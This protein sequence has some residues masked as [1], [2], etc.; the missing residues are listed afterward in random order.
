MGAKNYV[1][2]ICNSPITDF[3]IC[4]LVIQKG[5]N[6]LNLFIFVLNC[7]FLYWVM[8]VLYILWLLNL[9]YGKC[10]LS[11]GMPFHFT[12][13]IFAIQKNFTLNV[14]SFSFL[15][16]AFSVL[17]KKSFFTY[18]KDIFLC[19]LLKSWTFSCLSL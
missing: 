15:V 7:L 8:W 6:S 17:S 16:H 2:L 5:T 13:V 10:L 4:G 12:K 14:S 19:I 3:F 11:S 18:H 9:D 1:V